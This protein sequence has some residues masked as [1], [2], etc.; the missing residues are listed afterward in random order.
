M[1]HTRTPFRS[2]V[3]HDGTIK[4]PAEMR[5]RW[6][7][8]GNEDE[9]DMKMRW[10]LRDWDTR[11]RTQEKSRTRK[12]TTHNN[13]HNLAQPE[14]SQPWKGKGREKRTAS[15][16]GTR[17]EE[18]GGQKRLNQPTTAK[19][20]PTSARAGPNLTWR[21][22]GNDTS[23]M[24]AMSCYMPRALGSC[25]ALGRL[26]CSTLELR[27]KIEDHQNGQKKVTT[28]GKHDISPD[29]ESMWHLSVCWTVSPATLKRRSF[30][31]FTPLRVQPASLHDTRG[32]RWSQVQRHVVEHKGG[33]QKTA[34]NSHDGVSL[35]LDE[36]LPIKV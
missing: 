10:E 13:T 6:G 30:T 23:N 36:L 17:T 28:T 21:N 22:A 7:W 31:V 19:P 2:R 24:H 1:L 25:L 20:T 15:G 9:M 29:S 16:K 12:H 35:Y 33:R 3:G 26:A 32:R 27:A 4:V 34:S 18:G 14:K 5:W 8:E 11:K